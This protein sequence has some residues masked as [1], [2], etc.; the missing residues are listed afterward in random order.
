MELVRMFR[1]FA[2]REFRG[3]S[4]RYER[5]ALLLADQPG[6]AEPLL[7][8]RPLHRRAI[9]LFAA[10]QYL[11]RT[12]A[13]DHPLAAYCPTLGGYRTPDEGLEKNFTNFMRGYGEQLRDLCATRTTQTNEARRAALLRPGFG[14]VARLAAGRPLTLV[15]RGTSVR[16]APDGRRTGAH[17][18]TRRVAGMGPGDLP[19]CTAPYQIHCLI[20]SLSTGDPTVH[21]SILLVLAATSRGRTVRA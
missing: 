10:V 18:P 7:A 21:I 20:V 19:V 4:P 11:L 8:A 6:L 13:P 14:L 12:A 16:G 2:E 17:R 3:S 1:Y 15:E 9:L 5:L